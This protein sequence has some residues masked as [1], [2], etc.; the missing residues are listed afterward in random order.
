MADTLILNADGRPLSEVPLSAVPWTTATRLMF[1]DKVRIIKEYDDWTI[2]S[3][4]L[5][6]K[7]PSIVIMVKQVKWGKHLKYSRNNVYLRD[8][9][10][11]QLRIT[12]RC[13]DA[14]GKGKA[15]D[16]TLDHVVP[17]SMGGKT[18]WLNVCAACKPCNSEKGND[19]RIVPKKL[20]HKPSYYEILAKRK[21]LPIQI[22]DEDWKH[23][24]DW[25]ADLIKLID[26]PTGYA[27]VPVDDTFN[28]RFDA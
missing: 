19:A 8:D 2:R 1:L 10:T 28:S 21:T 6:I 18:T 17:K 7:V 11:C 5:E 12:N 25:P 13:K 20:P 9:Y 4:H 14:K 16:L 3:Q 26:Q 23:Y 24:I 27:S 15:V 22:R